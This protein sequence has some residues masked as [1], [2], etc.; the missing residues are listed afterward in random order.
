MKIL[1]K[2]YIPDEIIDISKDEVVVKKDNLIVTKWTPIKPRPDIGY[3]ISY[4]MLDKGWKVSKFFD[5]N[6]NFI[7]WYC[8]IIDYTFEEDTYT[9]IDLLVD[10]KVYE[11]GKYE[12]L[13]LDELEEARLKSIITLEQYN[14]ALKKLNELIEE[15]KKGKFPPIQEIVK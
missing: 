4:T 3:G 13:D 9:L 14:D 8:D 15:V 12:I 5:L 1:R 2:R 10:L 7:Y 6:G 11:D